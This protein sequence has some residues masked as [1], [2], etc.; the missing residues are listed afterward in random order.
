MNR[1][2]RPLDASFRRWSRGSAGTAFG[3]SFRKRRR[4]RE[5]DDRDKGR[6][7]TKGGPRTKIPGISVPRRRYCIPGE[8]LS[9]SA[10]SSLS[11]S[12]FVLSSLLPPSSSLLQRHFRARTYARGRCLLNFHDVHAASKWLNLSEHAGSRCRCVVAILL[13]ARKRRGWLR[14]ALRYDNKVTDAVVEL[15]APGWP[16]VWGCM[17]TSCNIP[18]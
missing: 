4:P 18:R 3:G 10:S 11:L 14:I 6:G 7:G 17:C 13:G 5:V 12:L 9:F 1:Y 15:R 16:Y 8:S 2:T